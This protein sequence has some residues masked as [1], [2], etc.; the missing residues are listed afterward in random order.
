MTSLSLYPHVR[1]RGDL[2]YTVLNDRPVTQDWVEAV[3]EPMHFR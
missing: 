3:L 2:W 1:E